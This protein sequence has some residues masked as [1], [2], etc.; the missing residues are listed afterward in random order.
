MSAA[1]GATRAAAS[2]GLDMEKKRPRLILSGGSFV[3]PTAVILVLLVV[4][5]LVYGVFISFFN[6]NLMNRWKFVGFRYYID[7]FPNKGFHWRILTTILFTS[8]T[9][10]GHVLVGFFL[11]LLL[12]LKLKGRA[13][14][15]SILIVPWL[16][17]EVVVAL[18]WRWML[19]PMYGIL[20]SWGNGLGLLPAD[21]SLLGN[22]TTAMLSAAAAA[23]WKG[24]PFMMVMI[25]AGLQS[26]PKE[27]Y[28]AASIDGCGPA[29][30]FFHVTL[31]GLSPVLS[32]SLILDTIW[33]FKHFTMIW[34]LTEGGPVNATKVV[35]IEIFKHAFEAFDYGRASA[36][37]VYVLL[38]CLVISILFRKA[39]PHDLK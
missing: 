32:V 21:F 39:I 24:Y 38:I 9:V 33:Y 15:R 6:T 11:A 4:W 7:I 35:S 23:I 29:D 36:M 16:F 26:I 2:R 28:E 13:L 5:P 19:H 22:G 12:N 14:F 25:L 20:T 1:A 31:P 34:L 18:L 37:A 30:S 3:V 8:L 27:H 17:P 10:S